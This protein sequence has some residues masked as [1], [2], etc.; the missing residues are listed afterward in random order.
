ML[1]TSRLEQ[2]AQWTN[3]TAECSGRARERVE[4]EW[5]RLLPLVIAEPRFNRRAQRVDLSDVI[6]Q[7]IGQFDGQPGLRQSER[8]HIAVGEPVE[9]AVRARQRAVIKAGPG[10]QGRHSMQPTAASKR[11]LVVMVP[12]D[13][14]QIRTEMHVVIS[15]FTDS[16]PMGQ[17]QAIEQAVGARNDVLGCGP[18]SVRVEDLV[19]DSVTEV[20]PLDAILTKLL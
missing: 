4:D 15:E 8:D 18:N 1:E 17:D 9:P 5:D 11:E 19:E 16:H 3:W 13:D 7:R 12:I 6:G 20:L 10:R 14:H 2:L